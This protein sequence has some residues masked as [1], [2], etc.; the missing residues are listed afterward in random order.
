MPWDVRERRRYED[1]VLAAARTGG[2]P[3]DL[4]VRYGMGADRER[5]L[6][7]DPEAF[8]AH[9]AAVCTYWR[10]LQARRRTLRRVLVDLVAAHERLDREGALTHG[11]FSRV[12]AETAARALAE[13]S[14]IADGLSTSLVD[15]W[16]L[17]AMAGSVGMPE[18]EAER[19]LRERGVRV[20]EQLPELP[21]Q[22]PV[23]TFR[24]LRDN[25]RTRGAVFSPEVV[26]GAGRLAGGF[27]VVDGFRLV[28]GGVLDDAALDG[29]VARVQ[30]EPL[31]EGKAAAENV[32][33]VLRSCATRAERDAVVLWEVAEE[34]RARPAEVGEA[35][36]ARPWARRGLAEAEA[37]LLAAAV[38]RR[39][40]G[41]DRV[42]RA[43]R[44]VRDLLADD[45]LR[46]AQA[47]AA[48]L[49]ADH[50]AAAQ[51]RERAVRV[52]E[53]SARAEE[54]LRE[55]RDEEAAR[56]LAAA[57]ALAADDD[58]LR[59]RLGEVPPLPPREVRARV[60]GR[61]AVVVWRPSPS[62]VGRIGYRVLRRVGRGAREAL[63]GEVSGTEFID[64]GLPVG[65]EVRYA[66]A[67]VREGRGTSEPGVTDPV[68]LAPEVGDLSVHA[69]E[70]EVTAAWRVPPEAVRVE[71]VRG[72]GAPPRG[73]DG[74][75]VATDGMG[76]RDRGVRPD[77]EYYY[78]VRAVYLTS[79][80]SARGSE[81][82][83]R[84]VVP[85]PPPPPVEDLLVVPD[86]EGGFTASWT[87]PARGRVSLR[88]AAARPPWPPGTRVPPAEV[89]AHGAPVPAVS[90]PGS[91]VPAGPY[92]GRPADA[93]P[94]SA[95]VT[96][97]K[98]APAG[99][100]GTAGAVEAAPAPGARGADGASRDG[101]AEGAL[102]ADGT[103]AAPARN[104]NGAPGTARAG[105]KDRADGIGDVL[106]PSGSAG[107]LPAEGAA[108]P[109]G[110]H[111][112]HGTCAA[113]R[114]ENAPG[115]DR[116]TPTGQDERT[117]R[118]PREDRAPAPDETPGTNGAASSGE[119]Q[120]TREA[121]RAD[122][123]GR[124]PGGT[125]SSGGT[126]GIDEAG[127]TAGAGRAALGP[128]ERERVR[129]E[130]GPGT[131]H[132]V[133]VTSCG[134]QAVVGAS[135]RVVAV[136]AVAGLHARRFG[137]LVRLG[138][139]WPEGASAAA[140]TWRPADPDD[141]SGPSRDGGEALCERPRYEAGG[142][143][144]APMGPGTARVA[145][146][147]VVGGTPG[148][149][150]VLTVPGGGVLDY[151]VAPA[152]LLRRDRRVTVAAGTA[153]TCPRI[154]VV[155]AEGGF[156]PDRV[157]QGLVLAVFPSRRLAAGQR[158]SLRVRPPRTA[159]PAWLV[160]LP[161]GD[162]PD[163]TRLC[164]PSVKE[165]RL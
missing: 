10:G 84:R 111:G 103:A 155:Y 47:A 87:P 83:V 161:L 85:G 127:G 93:P 154:A 138:W 30:V 153:C 24:S 102:G 92:G 56:A 152:G 81:G 88:T 71:V 15:R 48:D 3:A 112:A 61:G 73:G 70:E 119:T 122:R 125:A 150:A 42:A 134:D 86:G 132:V 89:A 156:P 34:L 116:D 96:G 137:D 164:Q 8:A 20:V 29:A 25:L 105:G 58:G 16:A 101:A 97:A 57:C 23:R 143:F 17:R 115:G 14:D 90:P 140:V 51:V 49:P 160:C 6:S 82:L 128:P 21:V 113:D 157:D 146:R 145:V 69:G 117:D 43:E 64:P 2:P 72:E 62:L 37:A 151:R 12:R 104:R 149:P 28:D 95:T 108:E 131:H 50:G 11:H 147:A 60:E 7:A 26:F 129:V 91:P 65:T 142:G 53:L 63:A 123:P 165:L 76:F 109:G 130:L 162:V 79:G 110:A 33:G 9:V 55:G 39:P 135:V 38:R 163:G 77:V 66:V 68:L 106:P 36:L 94:V 159:R 121:P 59:A 40:A 75:R 100:G 27:T 32:L 4:F 80:G 139:T 148:P 5:R 46:Q 45:Q 35:A 67:A 13:W 120:R 44:E 124:A 133:A 78:R 98:P 31:T 74:V 158:L 22:P 107:A 136:P 141:T 126:V 99:S 54:E 1:E 114:A 144:E 52:E 118:T 19:L 41:S 18:G